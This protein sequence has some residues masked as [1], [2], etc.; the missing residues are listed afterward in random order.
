MRRRYRCNPVTNK[1]NLNAAFKVLRGMGLLARQ[2]F[3][4]CSGCAGYQMALDA[5]AAADKGN[6]PK[7][8]V[9]YHKQ[10]AEGLRE[11]RD[12]YLAFGTVTHHGENGQATTY[13]ED[14]A[15]IGR[16]VVEV[17]N[18]HGVQTE[19]DGDENTRIK[20]KVASLGPV[21]ETALV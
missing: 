9:F 13:G 12:F 8:C 20:I 16:Q 14:T 4:C 1:D 2:S 15:A 3:L 18:R 17:L 10:D 11:N 5:K 19:W 6:P 7:G 21:S